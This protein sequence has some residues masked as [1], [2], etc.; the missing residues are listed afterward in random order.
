MLPSQSRKSVEVGV[1]GHH[2]ASMLDRNRRMLGIGDQFSGGS[3][4]AAQS[5]E[6]VQMVGAG[7]HDARRGPLHE[8]GH[9]RE[10]LVES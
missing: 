2:G 8:R 1:G 6:D 7:P 3:G 4:L 9:K 5:L 10:G